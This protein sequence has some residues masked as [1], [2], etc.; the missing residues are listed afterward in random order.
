TSRGQAKR[1]AASVARPPVSAHARGRKEMASAVPAALRQ[2]TCVRAPKA[3]KARWA[4]APAPQ[5]SASTLPEAATAATMPRRADSAN[6]SPS[7]TTTPRPTRGQSLVSQGGGRSV[8]QIGGAGGGGGG[9]TSGSTGRPQVGQNRAAGGS[10]PPQRGQV[11][12]PPLWPRS[13]P[14]PTRQ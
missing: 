4:P 9:P 1:R 6:S 5:G 2:T 12:I 3:A 7:R 11:A 13:D 14:A 8:G 10:S